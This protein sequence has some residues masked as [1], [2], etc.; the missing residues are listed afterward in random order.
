MTVPAKIPDRSDVLE[1]VLLKGDLAKLSPQE[2]TSF[3][4][5]VC[6]SLGLNPRTK[7][8]EYITLNGK[9]T[10]YALRACTDQL[11]KI[12]NVTLEI[13]SRDVADDILTVHVRARMPDGR[14]DEDLGAVHFPSKLVGEARVNAELKAVTKAKRRVTLSICGL[15]WLDETEVAD[16]PESAKRGNGAFRAPEPE[17]IAADPV[18]DHEAAEAAKN[19]LWRELSAAA[20]DGYDAFVAAYN[21]AFGNKGWAPKGDDYRNPFRHQRE[22]WLAIAREADLLREGKDA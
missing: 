1:S 3:Y 11:R 19:T 2:R 9:L 21:A 15:G 4:L 5:E 13:V 6:Q 7:P 16:I 22:N 8:F 18:I 17:K 14:S 10:L 20:E 12:N